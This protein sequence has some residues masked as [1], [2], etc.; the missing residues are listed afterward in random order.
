MEWM[1]KVD[2]E[3]LKGT[4]YIYVLL[5][6]CEGAF[7]LVN[8]LALCFAPPLLLASSCPGRG[9]FFHAHACL[10]FRLRLE[11]L[12][13]IDVDVFKGSVPL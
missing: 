6:S 5:R 1:L 10:L 13:A 4:T 2:H 7:D 11:S 9:V 3:H 8:S 12:N